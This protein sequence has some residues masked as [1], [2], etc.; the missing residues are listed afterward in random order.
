MEQFNPGLKNLVNLGKSYEKAV[1]AM[2]LAG[3]MYFEAV[4]KIGENA[5]VSPVSRELEFRASSVRWGVG[6]VEIVQFQT[7]DLPAVTA[8]TANVYWVGEVKVI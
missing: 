6:A 1:M 7:C 2:T 3:K 8:I 5:A 4:G